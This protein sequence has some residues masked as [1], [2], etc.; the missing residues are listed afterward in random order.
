MVPKTLG[1]LNIVVT[2]Q[3]VVTLT[4]FSTRA[5]YC[6]VVGFPTKKIRN[7]CEMTKFR[8]LSPINQGTHDLD[9]K[10]FVAGTCGPQA[11]A[12]EGL[13]SRSCVP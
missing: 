8:F 13:G 1:W 2:P 3:N 10:P 7:C 6:T 11:P 9:P 4:G 12:R 5:G